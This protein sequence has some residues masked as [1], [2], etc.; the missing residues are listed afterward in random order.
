LFLIV[1]PFVITY[2]VLGNILFG[3]VG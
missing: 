1:I 3:S 2:Y